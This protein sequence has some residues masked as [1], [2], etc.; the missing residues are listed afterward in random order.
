MSKCWNI[1]CSV[2]VVP[3][4]ARKATKLVWSSVLLLASS[5]ATVADR[6]CS[7]VEWTWDAVDAVDGVDAV[8]VGSWLA[9]TIGGVQA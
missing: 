5:S 4:S 3:T 7:S 8:D 6:S 9:S 2:A 1:P